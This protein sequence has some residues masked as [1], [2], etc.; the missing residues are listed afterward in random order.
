M[1]PLVQHLQTSDPNSRAFLNMSVFYVA[2]VKAVPLKPAA[3]KD[4]S[5]SDS[6]GM[7][8]IDANLNKNFPPD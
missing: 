2:P 7:A 3:K 5:S 1:Y 4:E 8:N 6:S